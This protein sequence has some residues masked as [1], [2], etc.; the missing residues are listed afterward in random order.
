MTWPFWPVDDLNLKVESYDPEIKD[1]MPYLDLFVDGKIL[2]NYPWVLNP[3][4]I[5]EGS[6]SCKYDMDGMDCK[7]LGM[8]FDIMSIKIK[9]HIIH[10]VSYIH[11]S[12]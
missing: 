5:M 4:A 8:L 1:F 3:M 12:S 6:P 10:R 9:L 2:D 7:S 11:R